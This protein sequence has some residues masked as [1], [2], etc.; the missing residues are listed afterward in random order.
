MQRL[1]GL[2]DD[3]SGSVTLTER[4]DASAITRHPNF[5]LFAAMNP[6]TDAGKKDLPPSIRSRFSELYVDELIDPLELRIIASRYLAAVLPNDGQPPENTDI[7]L[8][9]VD[10]YLK[11]RSLAEKTL[12]DGAG[13]KPRYT[14]RTLSRALRA[15]KQLVIQQ[16]LPRRRAIFEGFQLA[17]EGNLDAASIKTVRKL[18]KSLLPDNINKTDLEHPGKRPGGKADAE[19]YTLIKPFWIK[20]GPSE[21]VDWSATSA[22]GKSK[23]ILTPSMASS[24]RRLS[25][26]LASGD[27]PVL[28]EGPTS[29][30]KTT[31]VEYIAARCGHRVVRINNHE[32][33]GKWVDVASVESIE[34]YITHFASDI[35]EYTGS[36]AA[37][38]N[39]LLS[40]RD[41]LL[42]RALRFGYWVI[43][44]ELNLAPTEVLEAL[45][46]LLDDNRELFIAETNETVKPHQNF[47][48]FATQNPCGAYGG[49]KPLSRA[50][51]NRFVEIHMGD[52]PNAEIKTILEQ[53]C[54]CPPS[55]AKHLVNIMTSLR[56]RRS[57]SN[58]FLG[59]D[60][61]I[62]PRDLLRWAERKVSTKQELAEQGY[63][64]LAERL[65][66]KEERVLVQSVLEEN[67]KVSLRMEDHYFG[68]HS[69]SRKLLKKLFE[70]SKYEDTG[71]FSKIA[72]TT[73]LLRLI[74]L[75][76]ACITQKEPVLLVGGKYMNQT[77]RF[78]VDIN[79]INFFIILIKDTGCGKTTVVQ[80]LSYVLEKKLHIINCHATTETSDLLGGLRPVRGRQAIAQKILTKVKILLSSWPHQDLLKGLQVPALL[81]QEDS[82]ME[83]SNTMNKVLNA[84]DVSQLLAATRDILK[85]H[86]LQEKAISSDERE[87]KRRKLTPGGR[88]GCS[89]LEQDESSLQSIAEEIERLGRQYSALFEWSDGPLVQAMKAGD[90]FLLDEM[91]LAEDAVLERLNS[92]LEP[93]RTLVLAEKGE[94]GTGDI[95]TS[96]VVAEDDFRIFATMNPGGDFGK[97]EL[98][99]ALRSRFTE[100]WVPPVSHRADFELVLSRTLLPRESQE[101]TQ[102]SAV[103]S[104]MLTYVDWFNTNICGDPSSPFSGHSLTLRDVL[105]WAQFTVE[106]RAVN[107]YLG[108]WEAYCHGA[109]LMHLDGL[110]LGSGLTVEEASNVR[111]KAEAFLMEKMPQGITISNL[112]CA[113]ENLGIHQ[114]DKFGASPFFISTGCL[115]LHDFDFNLEAPTTAQNMFRVLRAMQVCKPV[116]LEG[117]PGVG[118][119]R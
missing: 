61:F 7:V 109:C 116:L 117:S 78:C 74:T 110:G 72:P 84:E 115:P 71:F 67:L 91:S 47:R 69:E 113:E 51:R 55:H 76:S 38:S 41:G 39:G 94:S 118:K 68:L 107:H 87:I 12:V 20:A 106:A 77:S 52:I 25:R 17:F 111:G 56:H 88:H 32:H 83:E 26:A 82:S 10:V 70:S 9:T 99:P 34:T 93:S 63:M 4:G 98:S 40:F 75:V 18:L 21:T 27:W 23:F 19:K 60:S 114:N 58:L 64:L 92:V 105:S 96:V 36:F 50:F 62:T 3:P 46:R 59:K 66:S 102:M 22:D 104:C 112:G 8:S 37:D 89:S 57:K 13:H 90:M 103:L 1:C 14:L 5:R 80:F 65:R 73:S 97:R 30:G 100:I 2:L 33:T 48:L 44:D 28:L 108:I 43:L 42:V 16:R 45:N 101:K 86:P 53:K 35:Q 15:A 24:L 95:K 54:G 31:L 79:D 29:A 6:A 85:T 119:T 11:C 49:R 81:S